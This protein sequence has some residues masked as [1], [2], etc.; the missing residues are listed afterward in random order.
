MD[1][2]G[3]HAATHTGTH[4]VHKERETK[5]RLFIV[6]YWWLRW[7]WDM[8]VLTDKSAEWPADCCPLLPMFHCSSFTSN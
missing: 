4:T 3:K 5:S 8:F 1:K 6:V 2:T 7:E